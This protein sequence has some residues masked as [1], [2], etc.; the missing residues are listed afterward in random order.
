[1]S[2]QGRASSSLCSVSGPPRDRCSLFF[3]RPISAR[4]NLIFP[5]FDFHCETLHPP[6]ANTNLEEEAFVRTLCSRF[7]GSCIPKLNW[8]I[9]SD[10]KLAL[11][12]LCLSSLLIRVCEHRPTRV[13]WYTQDPS[14]ASF[15]LRHTKQPHM[16]ET[17]IYTNKKQ[18]ATYTNSTNQ[19]QHY[20]SVC[21]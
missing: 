18:W 8:T 9:S 7:A 16:R 5:C 2:V 15:Q 12:A 20:K 13:V 19:T 17:S 10:I 14:I 4:G 3:D 21:V 6:F 1:M 11:N